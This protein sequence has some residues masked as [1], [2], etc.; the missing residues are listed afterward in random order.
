MCEIAVRVDEDE[1]DLI[2]GHA[3]AAGMSF[4][5]FV[6]RA[7]LERA[8]DMADSETYGKALD[9]AGG[10]RCPMEEV[11]RMAVEVE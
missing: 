6:K 7:V 1:R 10:N 2:Q 9:G 4:S 11:V 8:E 3:V 5:E